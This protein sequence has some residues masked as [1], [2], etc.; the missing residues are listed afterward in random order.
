MIGA[1]CYAAKGDALWKNY[2]NKEFFTLEP[3]A[4]FQ[5]F[6]KEYRFC[7]W[8]TFV[9]KSYKDESPRGSDP[10]WQFTRA[11]ED[12]NRNRLELLV[13]SNHICID[14]CMSAWRPCTTATRGLPNIT[15]IPRK[16]EPLGTEF[17]SAACTQTG[18]M[19]NLE[20]QRGREAMK[21]LRHNRQL[22]ATASCTLRLGEER[23]VQQLIFKW[24]CSYCG[25]VFYFV[26][27][28]SV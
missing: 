24:R 6:M 10:W 21:M 14:E 7:E 3:S 9:A 27:S 18:C 12:F 8:R 26:V 5:K 19:V 15:H 17:K 23:F 20:I 28:V 4:D 16:P 13:P 22:G 2:S 25:A 1:S 11:V